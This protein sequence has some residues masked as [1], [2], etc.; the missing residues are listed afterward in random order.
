MLTLTL[1]HSS[2]QASTIFKALAY[3]ST[4]I[5]TVAVPPP[6]EKKNHTLKFCK[7]HLWYIKPLLQ[8]AIVYFLYSIFYFNT[9]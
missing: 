2:L 7:L 5:N 6:P 8:Y 1:S 4:N 3:K 9:K